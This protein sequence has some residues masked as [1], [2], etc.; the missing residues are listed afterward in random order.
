[1]GSSFASHMMIV[2]ASPAFFI[3]G[4]ILTDAFKLRPLSRHTDNVQ[5]LTS[6]LSFILYS[7]PNVLQRILL[8]CAWNGGLFWV[9]KITCVEVILTVSQS[10]S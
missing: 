3:H 9:G 1:M 8:C 2:I 5:V 7:E 10:Y 4:L 6:L